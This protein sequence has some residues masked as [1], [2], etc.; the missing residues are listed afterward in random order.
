MVKVQPFFPVTQKH[1]KQSLQKR[2]KPSRQPRSVNIA[3]NTAAQFP[4]IGRTLDSRA[5]EI[6]LQTEYDGTLLTTSNVAAVGAGLQFNLAA[7]PGS[8]TLCALFDQYRID[9]VEVWLF[10]GAT[11]ATTG[12]PENGV[13]MSAVDL[14]SGGTPASF[15][16]MQAHSGVVQTSLLSAHYHS[17]VPQIADAAYSGAFTSF[18]GS[19]PVWIDTASSAVQHYGIQAYAGNSTTTGV[20]ITYIARL[21]CSFRGIKA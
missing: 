5:T 9:R 2:Q 17:F 6:R 1:G 11:Q 21:T 15:N 12:A 18:A 14:D 13:W 10:G 3:F 8:A 16:A 19:D 20:L 7:A 4:G